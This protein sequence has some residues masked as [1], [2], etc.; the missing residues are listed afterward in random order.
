M[1]FEV[2]LK[3]QKDCCS[4]LYHVNESKILVTANGYDKDLFKIRKVNRDAILQ[5][6]GINIPSDAPIVSFAGK[7]S[8]TKGIDH[9]LQANKLLDPA[10]NIHLIVIGAGNIKT[11]CDKMDPNSYSLKNVHIVGHQTPEHLAEIQN[12]AKLGVM[13]SRSEGFGISC[14]EAMGCGLPMVVSRC[15]GPEKF[16]V[17]R[18]IDVGAVQDL[19][20]NLMDIL[21]LSADD[22]QKLSREAVLA[23]MK[24]SWKDITLEHVSV[25]EQ[26][27]A[28][29]I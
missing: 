18:I 28:D 4:I 23:A 8:R 13:P 10:M 1:K 2:R 6:L 25:Y 29:K 20:T 15:G 24:F 22:Y 16:A 3:L 5:R 11:I 19:A 7:I 17:G 27:L 21:K 9:L 26:I 12:I 14:L